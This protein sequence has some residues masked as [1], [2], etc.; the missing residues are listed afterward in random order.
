MRWCNM[1]K[2][3]MLLA[4]FLIP[5]KVFALTLEW[6][7]NT[8]V[9]M[10]DYQVYACFTIGCTVVKQT[11]SLIGTIPHPAVGVVPQFP[12]T[13]G[14]GAV[15]VTARDIANNES[16]LSVSIPFDSSPPAAPLNLRL[17]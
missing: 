5:T 8:E 1:L 11:S 12:M 2:V 15:A 10:K 16:G 6:D 4:L 14:Q 13:V 17:R 3:I 9:D 7:R